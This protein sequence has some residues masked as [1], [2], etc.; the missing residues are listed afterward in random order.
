MNPH[1]TLNSGQVF[2][3]YRHGNLWYGVNGSIILRVDDSGNIESSGSD[4]PPDFFR[5]SDDIPS[6]ME[7]LSQ[8]SHLRDVIDRY[9]DMRITRQ[10]F[11][12]CVISFVVSSNSNIP[13]IRQNLQT[14]CDTFGDVIHM[15]GMEFSTFP[16]PDVLASADI[17]EITSCGTGYRSGYI[18]R[19]SAAICDGFLRPDELRRMPYKEARQSLTQLSGVGNKVADCI[20]LF[21]LDFLEAVPMDRWLVRV[22]HTQYGIGDGSMPG[23]DRAYDTLHD[24]AVR[25][26]GPYAGYAQQYLFKM[27]R[28]DSGKT[29][30]W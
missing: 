26:F 30:K 17:A 8:I 24:L 29:L 20:M 6:V 22:L 14:I 13:R 10:A 1:Q 4:T 19:T 12:Q 2:L 23:T 28:E 27:I 25:L 18:Q 3:W 15:D 5:N 7:S 21:S 11:F 16:R 9:P